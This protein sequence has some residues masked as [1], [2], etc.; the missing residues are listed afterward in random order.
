AGTADRCE[1]FVL[2]GHNVRRGENRPASEQPRE[3]DGGGRS[4]HVEAIEPEWATRC[5]R[6]LQ[7][8]IIR[9]LPDAWRR[10]ARGSRRGTARNHYLPRAIRRC[11]RVTVF[12]IAGQRL[13]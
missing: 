10:I 5:A 7:G 4:H 8:R 11:D 9:L 3:Y 1:D 12:G 2:R 13:V 6:H